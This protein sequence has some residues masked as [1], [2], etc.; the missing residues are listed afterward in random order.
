M[1]L[2]PFAKMLALAWLLGALGGLLLVD[3]PLSG[4]SRVVIADR[5]HVPAAQ[6]LDPAAASATWNSRPPWG[7]PPQVDIPVGERPHPVGVVLD[8]G[9]WLAIFSL[10]GQA[11]ARLAAD[12]ALPGG[13]KVTSVAAAEVRWVDAQGQAQRF[14]PLA[15][16]AAPAH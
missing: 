5:W 8:G 15:N 6:G 12:A 10:P 14:A 4:R 16:P 9:R 2:D 7:I 3:G 13:G 1:R 11:T